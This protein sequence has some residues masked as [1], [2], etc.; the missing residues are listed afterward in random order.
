MGLAREEP[1]RIAKAMELIMLAQR[2][3]RETVAD[4][5]KTGRE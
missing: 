3:E 4:A 5:S 1:S 2:T